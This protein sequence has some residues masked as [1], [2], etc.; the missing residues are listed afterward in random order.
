MPPF[1][2]PRLPPDLGPDQIVR[3]LAG[4]QHD[5][6]SR[7]QLLAADLTGH[8]VDSRIARGILATVHR[9]V[10]V[11]TAAP[12]GTPTRF[13]AALLASGSDA[14]LSHRSA[15]HVHGMLRSDRGAVHVTT[16]HRSRARPGIVVHRSASLATAVT[17]RDRLPCTSVARTLVDLAGVHGPQ[18]LRRA[19]TTLAAR[20]TLDVRAVRRELLR[21]PD[22]AGNS[23]VRLLLAEHRDTVSGA[24]RSY[25]ETQA[26]AMCSR[27][28][29]P[30]PAVNALVTV[31]DRV[32]EADLLWHGQRVIVELDSWGTHGHEL[33]FREDRQR[34]F[35]LQL[36][37]WVTVRLLETDLTVRAAQ[38]ANRLRTLLSGR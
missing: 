4:R 8:Q 38:T 6:V 15:A 33:S 2:H 25:L 16:T 29:L 19:W 23:A 17:T 3:W 10:F 26:I 18:T 28:G 13:A 35:A 30:M 21:N 37:G 32:Y 22:R 31:D 12:L 14:V 7:R 9:G 11:V 20:R 5:A 1:D 34:D 27:Y 36:A 24:A